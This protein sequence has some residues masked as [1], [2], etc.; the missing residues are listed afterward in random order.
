ILLDFVQTPFF[1][2]ASVAKE[3]GIIGSEIQMYQDD[4]GWR[5]YAGLLEN[6][7]NRIQHSRRDL[8]NACHCASHINMRRMVWK[9]VF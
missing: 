5:G 9:K 2:K 6:P 1:S 4:P 7:M 8:G 3:Q